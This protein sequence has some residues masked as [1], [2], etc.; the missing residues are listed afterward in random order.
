MNMARLLTDAWWSIVFFTILLLV[1]KCKGV[2]VPEVIRGLYRGLA[3]LYVKFRICTAQN[4]SDLEPTKLKVSL[5]TKPP[6]EW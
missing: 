6:N 1:F 5:P 4:V 2:T 3:I